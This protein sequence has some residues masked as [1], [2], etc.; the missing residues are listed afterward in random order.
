MDEF[1]LHVSSARLRSF[2]RKHHILIKDTSPEARQVLIRIFELNHSELY[3]LET[4]ANALW[5]C[6]DSSVTFNQ[7]MNFILPDGGLIRAKR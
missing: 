6:C 3:S 1:K 7:V 4:F 5:C 2:V